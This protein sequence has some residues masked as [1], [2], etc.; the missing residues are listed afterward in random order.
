MQRAVRNLRTFHLWPG[1]HIENKCYFCCYKYDSIT[2]SQ[3]NNVSTG[4][5]RSDLFFGN[6]RLSKDSWLRSK[7]ITQ[8]QIYLYQWFFYCTFYEKKLQNSSRYMH[9]E[10]NKE[11]KNWWG[12]ASWRKEAFR[13]LI[14][15]IRDLEIQESRLGCPLETFCCVLHFSNQILYT[16]QTIQFIH[17]Q[18]RGHVISHHYYIKVKCLSLS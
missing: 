18:K 3:S 1:V 6:M 9:E 10:F 16:I 11:N 7:T 12:T 5:Q 14:L 13:S 2:V 4:I 15:G 17:Q 8:M